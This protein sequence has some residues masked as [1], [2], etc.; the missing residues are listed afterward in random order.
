MVSRKTRSLSDDRLFKGL[1]GLEC[2]MPTKKVKNEKTP[3]YKQF[4]VLFIFYFLTV[5]IKYTKI[6]GQKRR[7]TSRSSIHSFLRHPVY[8]MRKRIY[9]FINYPL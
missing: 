1:Y 6:Y 5:Y 3:V 8:E 7:S 2:M 4:A 9:K